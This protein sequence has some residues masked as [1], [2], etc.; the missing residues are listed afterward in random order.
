MNVIQYV[1]DG[2]GHKAKYEAVTATVFIHILMLHC[3]LEG[4]R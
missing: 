1:P 2:T 3:V 4:N